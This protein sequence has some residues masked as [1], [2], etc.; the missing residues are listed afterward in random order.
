MDGAAWDEALGAYYADHDTIGTD[1]EARG[2]AL[3]SP[4]QV[5]AGAATGT[6][7]RHA[8]TIHD[9]E[10]D[11]DWVI[12]AVVDLDASDEAG[13]PVVLTSGMRRL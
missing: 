9:P 5:T 2:P 3:P 4:S 8:Q 11:H 1:S 10:G 13:E 7:G 12:E 6:A